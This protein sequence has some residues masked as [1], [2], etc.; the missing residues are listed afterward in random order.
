MKRKVRGSSGDNTG[1]QYETKWNF[2]PLKMANLEGSA[3][4]PGQY[5]EH[6]S[7]I[8]ILDDLF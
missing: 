4:T 7:H 3:E 8:H 2:N 6:T 5:S 1:T